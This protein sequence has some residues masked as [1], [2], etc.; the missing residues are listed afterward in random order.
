MVFTVRLF[1]VQFSYIICKNK[2]YIKHFLSHF[3]KNKLERK[4]SIKRKNPEQDHT[5]NLRA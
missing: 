1:N 5:V 3:Y 2:V 4:P